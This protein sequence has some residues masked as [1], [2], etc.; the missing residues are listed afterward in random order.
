MSYVGSFDGTITK[1]GANPPIATF[2]HPRR[3]A[4]DTSIGNLES[5]PAIASDMS[6]NV[7]SIM[8][9]F[10]RIGFGYLV[11]DDRM[12]VIK[13]NDAAQLA[14]DVRSGDSKAINEAFREL[15]SG[16]FCKF[17]TGTVCWVAIPFRGGTPIVV[18]DDAI[19]GSSGVCIVMLMS[20]ETCP[21]PNPARLQQMFGLTSAEAQLATSLAAGET[22]LE[23]ARKSKV[24]RTTIRSH[25]AA[26][27]SKTDTNRQAEL[28]A[29]LNQVSALP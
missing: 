9:M 6:G 1:S 10:G 16:V 13:W 4:S 12:R 21:H 18:H 25:L 11:L 7:E 20:R 22:P 17:T 14:L 8:A 26:L 19:V 3:R 15:T 23:I 2:D 24:S 28:V 29:L 5:I 27:F